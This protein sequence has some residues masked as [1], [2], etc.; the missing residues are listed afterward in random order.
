[1]APSKPV[2]DFAELASRVP[3]GGHIVIHSDFAE[4]AALLRQLV[5]NADLFDGVNLHTLMP[6][7]PPPYAEPDAARRLVINSFFYL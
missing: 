6:M 5:A 2:P 1:M 7:A 4:P 3:R